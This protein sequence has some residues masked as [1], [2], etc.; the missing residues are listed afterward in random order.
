MQFKSTITV[1]L[2]AV[3]AIFALASEVLPRVFDKQCTTGLDAAS[4]KLM[5]KLN[6]GAYKICL[7]LCEKS[8]SGVLQN[9]LRNGQGGRQGLE[10][11]SKKCP[12]RE[13]EDFQTPVKGMDV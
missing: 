10:K 8:A 7:G 9:L 1:F 11:R 6:A 13:A 3:P 5:Q 4:I 2:L 12:G